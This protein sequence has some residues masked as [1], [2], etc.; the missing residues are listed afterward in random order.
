MDVYATH[1]PLLTII[2]SRDT[3]ELMSLFKPFRLLFV[4]LLLAIVPFFV[5]VVSTQRVDI[6]NRAADTSELRI[7]GTII[8]PSSSESSGSG[9]KLKPPSPVSCDGP[10]GSVCKLSSCPTCTGPRCPMVAC[11]EA[12]GICRNNVCVQSPPTPYPTPLVAPWC[13]GPNGTSCEI[14]NCPLCKRGQ[15]CPAIACS[16]E[17]G[18]C[19]NNRCVAHPLPPSASPI[20]WKTPYAMLQAEKL[21]IT[22]NG[23]VFTVNPSG[24][25]ALTSDPTDSGD[26]NYTTL[27]AIWQEN[28]V[29]MRMF[30]YFRADLGIWRATELRIYNGNTQGDWIYFTG[31]NLIQAPLSQAY[32][33]P[34]YTLTSSE[35]GIGEISF[36]NLRIQAFLDQAPATRTPTP[37]PKPVFTPTPTSTPAP[38]AQTMELR[39]RLAGVSGGEANGAKVSVKFALKGGAVQQLSAPLTLSHVAGGVYKATAMIANPFSAGT[40]FRIKVKGEKHV[41]VQFC[42]Q[43][44]QTGPCL[45]T[46]YITVPN[47]VPLAYGFDLTGIPLPPGDLPPQDGRAD[48][49][50]LARM[51]PLMGKVCSSLTAAEKLVGDVDY[52]GCVNV[53]DVFLILQTLRTRY[54]E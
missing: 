25:L 26:Q 16:T 36:K 14:S 54:D 42:K 48:M 27:E 37:T 23:K 10:E 17:E 47:P 19:V 3:M 20:N 11:R 33:N 22:A 9:Y 21:T 24:P 28:G 8:Q 18:T 2:K 53:R 41:S 30:I 34:S 39:V 52:N 5:W 1:I 44:G 35:N 40:Q 4:L 50:D 51:K 6:R 49:Q 45:D 13:D 12:E 38:I 15:P 43:V 29:E 7:T 46:D 32:T 31:P